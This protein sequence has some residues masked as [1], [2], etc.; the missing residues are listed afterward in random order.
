MNVDQAITVAKAILRRS[1][2]RKATT[3]RGR[4]VHI[5]R[6][7]RDGVAGPVGVA[8]GQ[9]V[10]RHAAIERVIAGAA[11]QCVRAAAAMDGV[12]AGAA[13]D[14]VAIG[15]ACQH[16][17]ECRPTQVLEVR[18]KVR[19]AR[20]E[21]KAGAQVGVHAEAQVFVGQP[22]DAVATVEC[23]QAATAEQRVVAVLAE[24]AVVL[25]I[26]DEAVVEVAAGRAFDV[27]QR[28]GVAE[29][30][31][32][33]AQSQ[34][35]DGPLAATAVVAH[36]VEAAAAVDGVVAGQAIELIGDDGVVRPQN[37]VA[38][39][40]ATHA[41]DV[42]QHIVAGS[43]ADQPAA[44]IHRHRP[45]GRGVV[46]AVR[47]DREAGG[48]DAATVDAVVAA[49]GPEFFKDERAAADDGVVF[50]GGK[51]EV[52][53]GDDIG[54]AG[55]VQHDAAA[56]A[57]VAA[58]ARQIDV[59]AGAGEVE[60]AQDVEVAVV[61]AVGDQAAVHRVIASAGPQGVLALVAEQ[62][63]VAITAVDRVVACAALNK[64]V[65]GAAVQ[66]VVAAESADG[67][68]SRTAVER[69]VKRR[70]IEQGHGDSRRSKQVRVG[71]ERDFKASSLSRVN[72]SLPQAGQPIRPGRSASRR[73]GAAAW[74]D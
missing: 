16:V 8:V 6:P 31:G 23:V 54:A 25:R 50:L 55:A 12:I 72:L 48:R 52:D 70:A 43:A 47:I 7:G 64:I 32:G 67:V 27:E 38:E 3:D 57:A 37:R 35:D 45:G 33:R 24:E 66:A 21:G 44:Q 20:L 46:D 5:H 60:I 18:Q 40:R 34:I 42:A 41:V 28:V 49:L 4:Q 62:L 19:A 69:V 63:V 10:E 53:V 74:M 30:V 29:G 13:F 17:G 2:A 9:A 56:G 58:D 11:D 68:V 73:R 22:V 15:V 61:D 36:D 51:N 1:G 14:Q 26:A 59:D 39:G 71:R 65:A